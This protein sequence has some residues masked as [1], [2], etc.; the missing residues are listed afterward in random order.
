[1]AQLRKWQRRRS[2]T[3]GT[4]ETKYLGVVARRREIEQYSIL[5]YPA[6]QTAVD[7]IRGALRMAHQFP[8]SRPW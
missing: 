1:M 3:N 7:I 4:R 8:S 6:F 5:V 2:G